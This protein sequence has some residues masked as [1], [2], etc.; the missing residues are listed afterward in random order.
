MIGLVVVSA[1]GLLAQS[2]WL[3]GGSGMLTPTV[4]PLPLMLL[5][6]GLLSCGMGIT[7]LIFGIWGFILL[8]RYRAALGSAVDAAVRIWAMPAAAARYQ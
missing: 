1:L 5:V 6:A 7:A 3:I 8:L 2:F 4:S